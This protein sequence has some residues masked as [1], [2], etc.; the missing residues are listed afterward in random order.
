L[1]KSSARAPPTR[2]RLP[3]RDSDMLTPKKYFAGYAT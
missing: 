2:D 1:A 3:A